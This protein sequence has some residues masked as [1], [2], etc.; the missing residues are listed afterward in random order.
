MKESSGIIKPAVKPG[1]KSRITWTAEL[2]DAIVR[3]KK[4]AVSCNDSALE[5]GQW[6]KI[7]RDQTRWHRHLK[8][9]SGIIKSAV[10]E[11]FSSCITWTADIDEA[12]IGIKK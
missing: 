6:P 2:D 9:S 7:S 5:L 1:V 4:D 12:I 3:M 11:G 10:K 8:E